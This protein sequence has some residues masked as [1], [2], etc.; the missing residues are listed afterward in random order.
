MKMILTVEQLQEGKFKGKV[1]EH[2]YSDPAGSYF[3]AEVTGFIDKE[4]IH[5]TSFDIKENR[6]PQGYR[7]CKPK[8]TGVLIKNI[9][10][11]SLNMSFETSLT[12]TVGPAVLER[13]NLEAV[14]KKPSD[15]PQKKIVTK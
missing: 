12:C 2:F 14:T 5:F 3:N 11:Y 7:W 1:H 4:K 10:S 6:L 9:N 8:A 13:A 15:P